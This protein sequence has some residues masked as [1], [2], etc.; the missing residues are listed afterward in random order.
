MTDE[1]RLI[2]TIVYVLSIIATLLV[3]FLNMPNGLRIAL[4]ITLLI[5]QF[6]ALIWYTLSYIPYGRTMAR[7]CLKKNCMCCCEMVEEGA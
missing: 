1:K 6:C 5:I 3:C 2:V 7:T 4:L